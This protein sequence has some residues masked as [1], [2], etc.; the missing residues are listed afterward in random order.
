MRKLTTRKLNFPIWTIL[1]THSYAYF[2]G[3]QKY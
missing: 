3:T 1:K 2:T